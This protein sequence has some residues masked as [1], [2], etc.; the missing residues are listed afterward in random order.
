ML[1]KYCAAR[2]SHAHAPKTSCGCSLDTALLTVLVMIVN[3]GFY[4]QTAIK[5]MVSTAIVDNMN[6]YISKTLPNY[7]QA[8]S[9]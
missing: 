5:T 2:K 8:L 9:L 3:R 7:H 4:L 6:F 1:N